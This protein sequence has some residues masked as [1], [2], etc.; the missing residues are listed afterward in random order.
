M[1]LSTGTASAFTATGGGTVTVTGSTNT[2]TTTTGTALN[3]ANTTIG[4]ADVTFR[5][6]SANGGANGIVLNTT[7]ALGGLHVT[8]TGTAGSAARSR[9]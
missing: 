1:F 7:G 2:L 6:I 5:S 4:A 8:G 3:I 9:T